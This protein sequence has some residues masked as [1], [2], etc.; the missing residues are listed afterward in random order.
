M[1]PKILACRGRHEYPA[2][3]LDGS[4]PLPYAVSADTPRWGG[5][6]RGRNIRKR[7]RP[8]KPVSGLVVSTSTSQNFGLRNEGLRRPLLQR[9]GFFAHGSGAGPAVRRICCLPQGKPLFVFKV[10][11]V[12]SRGSPIGLESARHGAAAHR[13]TA[14]VTG[15]PFGRGGSRCFRSRRLS[16]P[17]SWCVLAHSISCRLFPPSRAD[18][19]LAVIAIL[20]RAF[21]AGIVIW[22]EGIGGVRE[23][24]HRAAHRDRAHRVSALSRREGLPVAGDLRHHD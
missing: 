7:P 2:N 20:L 21:G 17:S 4:R 9:R 1:E 19:P 3:R 23:G 18:W 10:D 8:V 16:L 11:A 22:R 5:V 15:S 6:S 12:A 24:H 13:S 14:D